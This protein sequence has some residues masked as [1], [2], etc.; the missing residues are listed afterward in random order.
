VTVGWTDNATDETGFLVERC[1][2]V[3]PAITC[4]TFAQIAIAPPKNNTGKTSF[5][6]VTVLPGNSYLYRVAAV[7]GSPVVLNVNPSTYL[8]LP[9]AN[10]AVVPAVPAA[11][12]TFTVTPALVKVGNNYATALNWAPYAPNPTN[13]TVQ[14]ASN[15]TFTTGLNTTNYAGN[16]RTAS[17]NLPK[18]GTY[19]FRIRANNSISGSSAW[20]N[21]L[22]YPVR[23]GP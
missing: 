9:D 1:N 19:Y 12:T 15:A 3:A 8:T 5:M 11:P 22:P 23:T 20:T 2:I 6:D 13:F 21:A 10:A 4:T 18:N 16:L 17:Q 14:R 7:N